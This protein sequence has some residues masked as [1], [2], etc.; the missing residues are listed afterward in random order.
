M[1]SS[2]EYPHEAGAA[3]ESA[4]TDTAQLCAQENYGVDPKTSDFYRKAIIVANESR[5]PFLVGGSYAFNR[6][7]GIGRKTKDFDIFVHPRDVEQ[8][9][10][11]FSAAGYCTEITAPHWLG[12]VFSGDDF[13][14]IIFGSGKGINDIDDEWFEHA[15]EEKI[16]G[17]P[18]RLCPPEEIIWS[19]SFIMERE[20]YDGA[21][22]AHLLYACAENLDWKRL[23]H[24][25]GAHWRLLF[26]HLILFG[27]IYPS[28]RA[29]IPEWV[30]VELLHRLNDEMKSPPPAERVCQGTLLSRNQYLVDVECHG[31]R[32]ARPEAVSTATDHI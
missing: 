19:K 4:D 29:R 8:I 2:Y 27:F 3:A 31:Y 12:K 10:K 26:S 21:D 25:F 1:M 22:I 13:V 23:L 17:M 14:D 30:T 32:D 9:M 24:R 15:V 7:T 6:F 16:L 18:V 20:R 28:D 5:V 11:V